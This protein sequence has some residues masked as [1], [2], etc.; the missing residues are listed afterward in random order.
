MLFTIGRLRPGDAPASEFKLPGPGLYELDFKV[1]TWALPDFD[2]D[3]SVTLR[4]GRH[5]V[6]HLRT[7]YSNATGTLT[8]LVRVNYAGDAASQTPE[9]DAFGIDD[10]AIATIVRGLAVILGTWVAAQLIDALANAIREVRRVVEIG[11]VQ[12][13]IGAGVAILLVPRAVRA[14]KGAF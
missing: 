1:P 4:A 5:V 2:N 10:L 12:W 14:V 9:I 8:M 7:R 3:R 13:A 6:Q 11:P